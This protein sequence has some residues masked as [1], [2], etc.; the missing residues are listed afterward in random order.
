MTASKSAATSMTAFAAI[1]V[2]PAALACYFAPGPWTVLAVAGAAV[3]A[4]GSM[5]LGGRCARDL[6]AVEGRER[7]LAT[8]VTTAEARL[9]TLEAKV[10]ESAAHDEVT[11][12]LNHR[13]FLGRL[14]EAIQR[15]RR[16]QKP[17]AFLLVDIE[18]FRKI[19]A[20]G[21]RIVGDRV[22][23][24]VG[25][26]LQSSTRGTDFVGRVGGDEFAVVL[27]ECSDPRPAVDRIFVALHG[28]TT[29]GDRGMPIVVSV[30]LVAVDAVGSRD[31]DPVRLFRVA[32]EA[33]A[34]VKGAGVSRCGKRDYASTSATP[35]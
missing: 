7:Q 11:G 10:R 22:L 35:A 26:A 31:V 21:G 33:L 20:D 17:M 4:T 3:A 34:S 2:M 9:S 29:G 14:D 8:S 16:L 15:D 12:A 19:N 32:E 18:G 13:T 27:G 5:V 6:E 24:T 30:G 28:E 1:G 23:R 25:R